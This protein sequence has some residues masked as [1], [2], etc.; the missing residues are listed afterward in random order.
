MRARCGAHY[1]A[2]K[3]RKGN[4]MKYEI[5]L[6]RYGVLVDKFTVSAR[7]RG[8]IGNYYNGI[9]YGPD[10]SQVI[11]GLPYQYRKAFERGSGFWCTNMSDIQRAD[12]NRKAD[13][14]PMG[15]VFAR[16]SPEP[17]ALP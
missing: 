12:M 11:V 14:A 13:G 7:K 15:S 8:A 4:V 10:E 16:F 1:Y 5:E 2:I 9:P 6:H 17:L 3:R